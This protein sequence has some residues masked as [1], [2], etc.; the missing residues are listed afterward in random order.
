MRALVAKSRQPDCAYR[1]ALVLTD[2][3]NAAGVDAARD[4]GV[5]TACVPANAYADRAAFDAEL[6][7]RI[8]SESPV[9]V[10][11]AG[12]MRILGGAFVARYADR[13]LNIHPS[14]LPD[15]PGLHTHRRVLAAGER[16]H[17]ATV[18]FVTATLDGGPPILQARVPVLAGDDEATLAARVQV[19][20]H[21]IYPLA[22]DWFCR[23]RLA[24]RDGQAWLDGDALTAP[25]RYA[26]QLSARSL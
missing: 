15:Y 19:V 14:L 1:V 3:P 10:I 2:N 4:L 22:V 6:A 18:H 12:F 8:D 24:H 13:L 16:V 25:L 26:E 5:A 23:G 9:L 21:E 7:A 20:E 11:L 17:G